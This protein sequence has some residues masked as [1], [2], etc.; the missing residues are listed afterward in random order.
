MLKKTLLT[1]ICFFSFLAL[2]VFSQKTSDSHDIQLQIPQII[3]VDSVGMSTD[4]QTHGVPSSSNT[5]FNLLV[6]DSFDGQT[7]EL[8]TNEPIGIALS[9]NVSGTILAVFASMKRISDGYM[10][11]QSLINIHPSKII[12]ETGPDGGDFERIFHFNP[13][14]KVSKNTPPGHYVC[15][16]TFTVTGE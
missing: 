3:T 12:F 10:I 15:L 2:P 14:V 11:D 9:Y 6:R 13:I 5:K 16:I 1:V 8:T 4:Q 7:W